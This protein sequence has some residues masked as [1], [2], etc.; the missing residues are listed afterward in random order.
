[1]AWYHDD[2]QDVPT[3]IRLLFEAYSGIPA[4]EV[5]AHVLKIVSIFAVAVRSNPL[6]LL[7]TV[8]IQSF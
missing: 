2:I 4:E 3:D 8:E 5:V 1:M 6:S 7:A